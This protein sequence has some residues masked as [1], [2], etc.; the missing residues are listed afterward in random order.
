MKSDRFYRYREPDDQAVHVPFRAPLAAAFSPNLEFWLWGTEVRT[1]ASGIST[2]KTSSAAAHGPAESGGN[3]GTFG[4]SVGTVLFNPNPD[5]N[6]LV[7]GYQ[8]GDLAIFDAWSR[9]LAVAV[10]ANA[11]SLALTPDGRTLATGDSCG[12]VQ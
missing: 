3:G 4:L 7:V 6:L 11:L 1:S 10:D 8:D 2:T 12:T 5:I 9:Q